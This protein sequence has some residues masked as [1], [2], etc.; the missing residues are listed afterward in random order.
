VE[1]GLAQSQVNVIV[2]DSA[3]YLWFGTGNGLSK[4][5]GK[6]F[7]N[8]SRKDGIAANFVESGLVDREGNL[9]FGHSHGSLTRYYLKSGNFENISLWDG[10]S[11]PAKVP[12]YRIRQ[13]SHSTIWF[14]TGGRGLFLMTTDT[15]IQITTANGLLSDVVYDLAFLPDGKAWIATA[16]GISLIRY[17]PIIHRVTCDSLNI[18]GVSP[19]NEIRALH[20]DRRGNMW[21]GIMDVGLARI[22]LQ[23]KSESPDIQF[24]S[25][26]DGLTGQNIWT[27]IQDRQGTIWV[28]SLDEGAFRFEESNDNAGKGSFTF[29]S[30]QN[31]LGSNFVTTIFE[32]D[33]R[34]IWFGTDGSGV[35]QLRDQSLEI[36][37][38]IS[39]LSDESI[40]KILQDSRGRYWF[41]HD[42][43]FSSMT[44]SEIRNKTPKVRNYGWI[45]GQ[46]IRHVI[47]IFEDSRGSLWFFPLST[48]PV[49]F[50]MST[51]RM[52]IVD[53]ELRFGFDQAIAVNEDAQG[54]LWFG[55]AYEGLLQFNPQDSSHTLINRSSHGI[56]CDSITT[57]YKDSRGALWFGTENGGVM[58]Y[59]D[60]NFEIYSPQTGYPMMSVA[61]MTEDNQGRMWFITRDDAIYRLDG[62][63][64]EPIPDLEGIH[65]QAVYSLI[66]SGDDIWL[67][68]NR[69]IAR[70]SADDF[71]ITH[72]GHHE[73]F[74]IYEANENAVYSDRAGNIWFGTVKGALKVNPENQKKLLV[75]PK[76]NI[77][78]VQVFLEDAIWPINNKFK[79]NQ[80][81]LTFH[82]KGISHTVPEL[83]RYRY[84][85]VGFDQRWSPLVSENYATYS[86]LSPGNY[87]FKVLALNADGNWNAAPAELAFEIGAPFW[88]T[89]WFYLICFV[90]IALFLYTLIKYRLQ[91]MEK[92]RAV[93]EKKVQERTTELL[94][95]KEN[96]EQM[97]L[98][99]MAEKE[100]LAVTLRSI[101]D[102]VI[103]TDNAGKIGLINPVAQKICGVTQDEAQDKDLLEV[104]CVI[105]EKTALPITDP[106]RKITDSG[107]I[108]SSQ[109]NYNNVLFTKDGGKKTIAYSGSP[110]RDK[111]SNVMGVVLVFRDITEQ[112]QIEKELIKSQKLESLG[113]LAGGI[114][115]DF[116]NI[117]TAIT[118]N[119]SLAK[120]NLSTSHKIYHSL[121]VVEQA[122]SRAEELIQQLL[123]FSKG[124]API[125]KTTS[126]MDLVK[127]SAEFV[128]RGSK[129]KCDLHF[130]DAIFPVDVDP[131]QISQ[132]IHNIILN[133]FQA[134]PSGGNIDISARNVIIAAGRKVPVDEGTYVLV[135]IRDNGPG[136]EKQYLQKIFDPFFTT[137]AD[138]NGLGLASSY[139]IMKRHG[140][141]ISAESEIGKGSTFSLYM[142]AATKAVPLKIE[143][144]EVDLQGCGKIL[145][146]DDEYF[147]RDTASEMLSFLGF[148][149]DCVKDGQ[150]VIERYQSARLKNEPYDLVIMDLTIPGGMGGEAALKKLLALDPHVRAVVSSGY[151]GDPIMAN[152]RK[153][154]FKGCLKKP[155]SLE[156]MGRLMKKLLKDGPVKGAEKKILTP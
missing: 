112:L 20:H 96:V 51:G 72:F 88:K 59:R 74:P 40:W 103:T 156:E 73:G 13:D 122:A 146:M 150:E 82:F 114:A 120:K 86:N 83:V 126:I 18:A 151:S 67:G 3:G 62:D 104:F 132:V 27:I 53:L 144:E 101:A 152:Y 149:V 76:I 87:V 22:N 5:D 29:I 116:N 46:R 75:A 28:G 65:G 32:D 15:L 85:L 70:L 153:Y 95:E 134:M 25:G 139:S 33:E 124:G 136:I 64:M 121:E 68:T 143:K 69:G 19:G 106:V 63:N 56:S 98:A 90:L 110:I 66:A 47:N 133:A 43:G 141:H 91:E 77:T 92:I 11:R 81:H 37:T 23:A 147:V 26:R 145:I 100:R 14:A 48:Q 4:F 35:S 148:E 41:G 45:E 7:V 118:G 97:N 38:K 58:R 8:F 49:E 2:Q 36:Y 102:G 12:V 9:W 30:E 54:N 55:S 94:R 130:E 1:H 10:G 135:E 93:L 52:Q 21:M 128:L 57:I 154:G 39:G 115:H 108:F 117:L 140:G 60:Q 119:I 131:G 24:Y 71:S 125:K 84:Y 6:E 17:D 107:K 142:P 155:F 89:W 31:G 16:N 111:D 78:K 123:T 80:N 137:K 34:N 61:S 138:G 99:L 129:I 79:Y 105:D 127:E 44:F 113:I 42:K 50:H 109:N